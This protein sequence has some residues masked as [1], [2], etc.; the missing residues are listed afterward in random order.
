VLLVEAVN[1]QWAREVRRASPVILP[2]LQSL[3]GVDAVERIEV[4]RTVIP[5]S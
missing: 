3:L 5:N 2:R 1:A 4:C